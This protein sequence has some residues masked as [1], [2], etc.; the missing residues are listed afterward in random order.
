LASLSSRRF[1]SATSSD[2]RNAT[3]FSSSALNCV[4]AADCALSLRENLAQRAADHRRLPEGKPWSINDLVTDITGKPRSTTIHARREPA[5]Q[6]PG[7]PEAQQ[8]QGGANQSYR[9]ENIPQGASS[10]ALSIRYPHR[11]SVGRRGIGSDRQLAFERPV[12]RPAQGSASYGTAPALAG[13]CSDLAP[14]G[15]EYAP[16]S[17][18]DDPGSREAPLSEF[19]LDELE[20]SLR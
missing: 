19:V 2:V 17:F 18:L 20:K 16:R 9:P 11:P 12:F 13:G 7:Q 3:L 5:A 15:P 1:I 6:R 4:S 14:H 8:H 10:A